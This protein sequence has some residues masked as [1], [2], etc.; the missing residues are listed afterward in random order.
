MLNFNLLHDASQTTHLESIKLRENAQCRD[1][2]LVS[3]IEQ[4]DQS[5]MSELYQKYSTTLNSY[6][7]NRLNDLQ[8]QS[9]ILNDIFLNLW[10][11]KIRW[12]RKLPFKIYMFRALRQKIDV[13][14]AISNDEIIQVER[15]NF[16]WNDQTAQ[17]T[18]K[19]SLHEKCKALP[20]ELKSLLYVI[21]NEG[22][23]YREVAIIENATTN[24]IEQRFLKAFT[25]IKNQSSKSAWNHA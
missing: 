20:A 19:A 24:M 17:E 10:Q 7:R 8:Y 23:S 15:R 22:L 14:N 3:A 16:S 2:E 25:L 13:Q 9:I 21:Y 6:I 5:S 12:D 18:K 11:G 1:E 4:G